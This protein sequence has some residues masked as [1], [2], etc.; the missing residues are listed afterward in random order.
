MNNLTSLARDTGAPVNVIQHWARA[1]VLHAVKGTG[2]KAAPR[3]F[4]RI[5]TEIA[6]VIAP[7][8]RLSVRVEIVREIASLLRQALVDSHKAQNSEQPGRWTEQILAARNGEDYWMVVKGRRFNP[9]AAE[10]SCELCFVKP[11]QVMEELQYTFHS[12]VRGN[13]GLVLPITEPLT[14]TPS[15][16]TPSD[17]IFT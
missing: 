2:T 12:M 11:D 10:L 14:R 8:S 7:L 16:E 13:V 17:W 5:E 4:D 3:I 1:N 6:R 9:E 15:G